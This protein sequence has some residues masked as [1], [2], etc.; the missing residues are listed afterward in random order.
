MITRFLYIMMGMQLVELALVVYMV[1]GH[2]HRRCWR[3]HC[4]P[5]LDTTNARD[6][7][8]VFG[9]QLGVLAPATASRWPVARARLGP[10]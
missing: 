5:K 6:T 8:L 1:F 4:K 2:L 3:R 9:P 7:V 10:M